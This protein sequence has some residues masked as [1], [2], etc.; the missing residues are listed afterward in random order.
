MT[1]PG[2][3]VM[4]VM[5]QRLA[6]RSMRICGTEAVSSFFLSRSR[7]CRSSVRSLPNSFFSAYHLERQS[8]LTAMRRPIGFVFCPMSGEIDYWVS[9][10][11]EWRKSLCFVGE[12]NFYVAVAL[13]NGA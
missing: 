3:A 2:R 10:L 7:I 9:G 13:N 6:A 5:R 4:M 8:L 1:M 12:N 11:L